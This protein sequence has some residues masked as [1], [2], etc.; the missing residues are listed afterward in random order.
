MPDKSPK[1]PPGRETSIPDPNAGAP[2]PKELSDNGPAIPD[3]DHPPQIKG[4]RPA[5]DTGTAEADHEA[6]EGRVPGPD[7]TAAEDKEDPTWKDA[8]RD[9]DSDGIPR[10][11]DKA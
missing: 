6:R 1:P 7:D 4:D 5:F 10:N 2:R 11:K 3:I 8:E 9:T